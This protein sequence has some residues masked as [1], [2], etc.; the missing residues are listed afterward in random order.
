[1]RHIAQREDIRD[2]ILDAV[3]TL[4]ARYGYKK[5]TMEDLAQQVGIGKGTIYLHF[6]TKKEAV[7]SHVDRI[8]DS[9]LD[10]LRILAASPRPITWR[11]QNMLLTR[12]LFRIDSVR[13]YSQSLNDLL[14]S[15]RPS[16]LL[17]RKAHFTKEAEVFASLLEEGKIS[18]ELYVIDSKA[19]AEALLSATNSLLPFS[20]SVKELGKRKEIERMTLEI[21]K[22]LLNGLSKK[23]RSSRKPLAIISNSKG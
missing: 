4:L 15:L 21:V 5:M 6:P 12:V 2:L 3:D 23:P 14:S 1:M 18:K 22:I 13:N 10:E 7:L 11:L 16:F 19:T 17:R 20:L 9:L 8:V